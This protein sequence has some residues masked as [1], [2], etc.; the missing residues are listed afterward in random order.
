MNS[1]HNN[2]YDK[3]LGTAFLGSFVSRDLADMSLA[4]SQ[5]GNNYQLKAISAIE[6]KLAITFWPLG[7][8][9]P[10]RSTDERPT[11]VKFLRCTTC[12]TRMGKALGAITDAVECAWLLHQNHIESVICYNLDARNIPFVVLWRILLRKSLVLVAADNILGS[13]SRSFRQRALSWIA[14]RST[15]VIA[16]SARCVI[17]ANQ[18]LVPGI[19]KVAERRT[20]GRN[21][22]RRVLLCGSLGES[23]GAFVAIAA[24]KLLP[25][26]TFVVTGRPYEC[27]EESI[28]AKIRNAQCAGANIEYLGLVGSDRFGEI[29]ASCSM[30]I[31]L[32]DPSRH[33]HTANFPSK[34]LELL[35]AGVA[36]V[37]NVNYPEVPKGVL[38]ITS[39]DSDELA[40]TLR[41]IYTASESETCR[42]TAIADKFLNEQCSQ[43]AF[44]QRCLELLGHVRP[45]CTAV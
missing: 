27:S 12:R 36:V 26:F 42:R 43:S 30:G 2:G 29:L 23:T 40:F 21:R 11:S 38:W 34:I 32:R 37:S 1:H 9:P 44:K 13:E 24:S 20:D 8:P 35:S 45:L 41:E 18:S 14:A 19:Q 33:E 31:S 17:C 39:F 5:A 25:E 16:L 6:P 22:N 10:C 3:M 15:G 7:A 28:I 4:I